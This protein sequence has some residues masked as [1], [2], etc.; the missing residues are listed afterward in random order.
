ML[1][2]VTGRIS[3]CGTRTECQIKIRFLERECVECEV[4][5]LAKR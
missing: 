4:Q 3:I 5:P 1:S 2:M